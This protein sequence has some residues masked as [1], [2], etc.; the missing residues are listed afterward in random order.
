VVIAPDSHAAAN[1]NSNSAAPNAAR[2]ARI[3]AN[4]GRPVAIG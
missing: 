4:E 1:A 2:S 3:E